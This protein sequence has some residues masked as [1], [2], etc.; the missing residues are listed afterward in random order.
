MADIVVGDAFQITQ[1]H[2][3]HR[4]RPAEGLN[5][6][7]LVHGQHHGVIRRVQIEAHDVAHLLHEEGIGGELKAL[8]RW[9]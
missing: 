7:F 4:L 1:P 8:L 9:G 3:Q 2:G 6:R 5:L